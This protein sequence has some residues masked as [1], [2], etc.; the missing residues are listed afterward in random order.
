[1][2]N[3]ER[4][5]FPVYNYIIIFLIYIRNMIKYYIYS[6]PKKK[7]AKIRPII[8]SSHIYDEENNYTEYAIDFDIESKPHVSYYKY[9]VNKKLIINKKNKID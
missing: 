2:Y 4:N 5:K 3:R 9:S 7:C 1:M 8:D 6:E